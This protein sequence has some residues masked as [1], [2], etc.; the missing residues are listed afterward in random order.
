MLRVVVRSLAEADIERAYLCE[1]DPLLQVPGKK[2]R[3]RIE[4]YR[5]ICDRA[6]R[7]VCPSDPLVSKTVVQ[8]LLVA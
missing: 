5:S 3:S 7:L 2:D 8:P 4:D 1:A 6:T